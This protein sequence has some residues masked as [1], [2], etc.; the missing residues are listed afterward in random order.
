[1]NP[2]DVNGVSSAIS[3]V[4]KVTGKTAEASALVAQLDKRSQSITVATA[5]LSPSAR[6]RVFYV[7]WHDPLMTAGASTM[8]DDLITRTGGANIASDLS[9][10]ATINLETVIQ[11][12]PQII[13]VISSMGD[14]TSFDY[15]KNEPRFQSTEAIKNNRIYSLDSDIFGRTTPR[16]VDGMEQVAKLIHPEIFK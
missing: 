7:V 8:I 3:L 9:G 10:Y 5:G 15:I 2:L 6:P 13:L 14:S 16:I 1:L 12:N 11:R 4:G